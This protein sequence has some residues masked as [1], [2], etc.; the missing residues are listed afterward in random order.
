[1]GNGLPFSRRWENTKVETLLV[2]E[3]SCVIMSVSRLVINAKYGSLLPFSYFS[4]SHFS[5]ILPGGGKFKKNE[6]E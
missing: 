4:F 5:F 6:M 3:A 1:M 2:R